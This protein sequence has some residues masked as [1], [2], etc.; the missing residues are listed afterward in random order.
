MTTVIR[1]GRG[2]EGFTAADLAEQTYAGWSF[3]WSP[4]APRQPGLVL[5]GERDGRRV[6]LGE[7]VARGRP[8][9][10]SHVWRAE[11]LSPR[12]GRVIGRRTWTPAIPLLDARTTVSRAIQALG[13]T[14]G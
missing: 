1:Y 13:G 7:L 2:V 11:L 12:T 4:G 10:G 8:C 14:L 5:I 9:L 3:S 6:S